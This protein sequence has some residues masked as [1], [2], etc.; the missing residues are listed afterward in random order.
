MRDFVL[1]PKADKFL[2]KLKGKELIKK[3]REMISAICETP[4]IGDAKKGDLK[5]ILC[6]DIYHARVN[7]EI[8]YKVIEDDEEIICII[9]LGVRENFYDDLKNYLRE[10]DI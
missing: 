4:E 7:Y 8:A 1:Y 3:F 2:R 10:L 5:G 6:V 9:L